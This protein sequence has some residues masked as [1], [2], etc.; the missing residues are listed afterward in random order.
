[1]PGRAG[2]AKDNGSRERIVLLSPDPPEYDL[3]QVI[4]KF[5]RHTDVVFLQG[6]AKRTADLRRAAV[7]HARAVFVLAPTGAVGE[8]TDEGTS[9]RVASPARARRAARP[10]LLTAR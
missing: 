6:S 1:M 3:Q 8:R 10:P 4:T 9:S 7:E 5:G 2:T